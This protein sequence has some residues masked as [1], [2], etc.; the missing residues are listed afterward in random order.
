MKRTELIGRL[1]KEGFSEKTL[2]NFSDNQLKQLASRVLG[3]GETDEDIMVSKND[4]EL[5]QKVA[6]AKQGNKTIETYEELKGKQN[7]I[8]KNNNGEIDAEDF[9]ILNKE[10]KG[11]A[12]EDINEVD[13]GLTVKGSKSSSSSVFGGAPK[14]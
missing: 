1:L 7:K 11:E 6:D 8:D 12:K 5:Q 9:A 10:K 3:E 13:M 14:K 2:V 4:P